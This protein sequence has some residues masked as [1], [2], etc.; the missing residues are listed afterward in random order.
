MK[1]EKNNKE[2]TK[3]I[4]FPFF[5]YPS[6]FLQTTIFFFKYKKCVDICTTSQK[7]TFTKSVDILSLFNSNCT[8]KVLHINNFLSFIPYFSYNNTWQFMHYFLF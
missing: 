5:H 2:T 7:R 1:L 3:K 8:L 6:Y 4:F